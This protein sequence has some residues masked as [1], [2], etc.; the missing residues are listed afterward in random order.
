MGKGTQTTNYLSLTARRCQYISKDHEIS[1]MV[2]KLNEAPSYC[3]N[4]PTIN[5]I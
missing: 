4:F 2:Q 1:P 5:E 3:L